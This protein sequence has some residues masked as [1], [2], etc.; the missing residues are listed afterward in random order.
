MPILFYFSLSSPW[1]PVR[2]HIDLPP[3]SLIFISIQQWAIITHNKNQRKIM[4]SV[5]YSFLKCVSTFNH[6]KWPKKFL[7]CKFKYFIFPFNFWDFSSFVF[8]GLP[9]DCVTQLSQHVKCLCGNGILCSN[10]SK[11]NTNTNLCRKEEVIC[12]DCINN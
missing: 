12:Q 3:W 8:R 4:Y 11:S 2:Y 7:P 6:S 5:D 10:D 1:T 9:W